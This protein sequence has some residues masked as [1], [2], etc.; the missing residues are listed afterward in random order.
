MPKVS[1]IIPCYNLGAYLDEAVSSV[2]AQTFDD[3]EIL[4]VNDGS[5]DLYT[6]SVLDVYSRPKTRVIHSDNMGVSAARNRGILEAGGEYIL[7][8]D[9]DDRIGENYLKQA[10]T[11]LDER[12]DVGIVYCRGELFGELNGEWETPEFSLAHQLL[13]NLIFSAAMFRKED[14]QDTRGYDPAMKNGWEDWDFW[15][16]LL[17]GGKIAFRLPEILFFY[18]IR[19]NSR[20]RSL[21]FFE[22]CCLMFRLQL[23]HWKLFLRYGV[24]ILQIILTRGRRRPAPIRV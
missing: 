18:R 16:S 7:P 6:C 20:D 19:Q 10:V 4:V 2:L 23:N 22:K 1:V 12:Q 24:K 15:L 13:D 14:W 9:A 21:R 11:I 17:D 5:T 8:L 3:Y